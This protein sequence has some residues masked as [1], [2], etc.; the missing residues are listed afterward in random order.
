MAYRLGLPA[1][2]RNPV[3]FSGSTVSS[4][5]ATN[6]V[7]F[8]QWTAL[9]KLKA[10]RFDA[11]LKGETVMKRTTAIALIAMANFVLAGTSFAQ[12]NGVR[13]TVPFDFTVGNRLLPAGTYTIEKQPKNAS[14]IMIR[15]HDKPIATLSLVNPDG[16]KSPNGGKLLFHRY[17]GQYF[18]S[19]ILCD[20]ADMNVAISASKTEKRAKL[21]QAT[22]NSSGQ[23]VVA[24]Q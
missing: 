5:K 21:Q 23:T 6:L 10:I 14:V 17:G 16:N 2:A 18:L 11:S 19:E 12:S 9:N 22:L 3:Y 8:W 7:P 24:A 20:Q 13:A 1:A 15:S 4:R